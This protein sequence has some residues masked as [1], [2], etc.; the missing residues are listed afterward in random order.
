MRFHLEQRKKTTDFVEGYIVAMRLAGW[1]K[2]AL[3]QWLRDSW[4][5]LYACPPPH[6]EASTA[7]QTTAKPEKRATGAKERRPSARKPR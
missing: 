4:A 3:P 7:G 5:L 6:L 2:P 1:L